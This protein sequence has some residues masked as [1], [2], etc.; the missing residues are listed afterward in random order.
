MSRLFDNNSIPI[1]TKIEPS[2]A[3]FIFG[4]GNLAQ[5]LESNFSLFNNAVADMYK[6]ADSEQFYSLHNKL[7]SIKSFFVGA[8]GFYN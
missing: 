7:L 3:D 4:E 6:P 5:F 1:V 2:G 8:P